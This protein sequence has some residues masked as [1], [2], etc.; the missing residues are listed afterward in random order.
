[1]ESKIEEHLKKIFAAGA[2]D[3]IINVWGK[4]WVVSFYYNDTS[5]EYGDKSLEQCL[6]YIWKDIE[7]GEFNEKDEEEDE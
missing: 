3:I 1:M 2:E 5:I 6:Q 4:E 7:N